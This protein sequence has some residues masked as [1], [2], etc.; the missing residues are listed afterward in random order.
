MGIPRRNL[1]LWLVAAL[2]VLSLTGWWLVRPGEV[3]AD[4]CA[5][6]ACEHQTQSWTLRGSGRVLWS[7]DAVRATPVSTVLT[8]KKLVA[9]HTHRWVEPCVVP[10]PLNPYQAPVRLSLGFIN[11]S[12]VAALLDNIGDYADPQSARH[13]CEVVLAPEYSYLINHDLRF[14]KFP[15]RG[16]HDRGQFLGWWQQNAF[17]F[18]DHL[19]DETVPD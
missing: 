8:A 12:L 19:R 13:V 9:S 17:S 1:L 5:V 14:H 10:N 6:C 2:A 4:Y 11:T 15:P 3:H 16:F 18:F 7:R